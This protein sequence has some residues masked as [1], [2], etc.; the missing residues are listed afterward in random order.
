M[1]SIKESLNRRVLLKQISKN[2]IFI[3]AFIFVCILFLLKGVWVLDPDFG[4]HF[5]LG[6]LYWNVGNIPQKDS[7][8]YTMPNFHFIDHEWVT[9]I[10]MYLV[11]T[12]FSV[13]ILSFFYTVLA[14]SSLFLVIRVNIF[15]KK[16]GSQLKRHFLVSIFLLSSFSIMPSFGVRPQV[17]SWFLLALLLATIYKT[18]QAKNAFFIF[19]FLSLIWVNTHGSFPLLLVVLAAYAFFETIRA[20]TILHRWTYTFIASS[21]ATL[22]NPYGFIIWR[23]I[24][25]QVTATSFSNLRFEI[26]E[27]MP[28]FFSLNL[29]FTFLSVFFTFFILRFWRS[30]KLEEL[31][32][33]V[34]FLFQ[35]YSS[36][37]H[38]PLWTIYSIPLGIRSFI[39]FFNTIRENNLIVSRFLIAIRYLSI[40][41]VCIVLIDCISLFKTYYLIREGRF[42]P[43]QA[44][45]YLQTN[46]LKDENLLAE[47]GWGGYLIWKYPEKKVFIDGRMPTWVGDG[48]N[49]DEIS[50]WKVYMDI[51]RGTIDYKPEFEKYRINYVLLSKIY[52][53][54]VPSWSKKLDEWFHKTIG[55]RKNTLGNRLKDDGWLR[56]YE[57]DISIIYKRPH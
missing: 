8:S 49:G 7:F 26:S 47:F 29:S 23:E 44:I 55:K 3:C 56:I 31:T 14:L 38:I 43:S 33:Y 36:L 10:G 22:V 35:A 30:Y 2:T 41:A 53:E 1:Y 15:T 13:F 12:H 40:L 27:W 19:P 42:Y 28:A 51:T 37:R 21:L 32:L 34:F 57:D 6:E 48:E 11:Y 18:N 24:Y 20:K 5:K 54:E 25:Q 4:W 52:E 17:Q 9:N 16:I 39:L 50:A 45:T 46:I